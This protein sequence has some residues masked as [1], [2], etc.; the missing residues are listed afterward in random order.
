MHL[1]VVQIIIYIAPACIVP[2][3][4]GIP[5]PN[6]SLIIHSHYWWPEGKLASDVRIIVLYPVSHRAWHHEVTNCRGQWG[7]MGV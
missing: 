5:K 2:A 6:V 4:T 3:I 1:L 7:G